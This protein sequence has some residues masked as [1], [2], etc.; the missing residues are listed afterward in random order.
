MKMERTY[1]EEIIEK[2]N[3]EKKILYKEAMNI[4]NKMSND[5]K[6]NLDYQISVENYGF[7]ADL[8]KIGT[9]HYDRIEN[10]SD[11]E[12]KEKEL[13]HSAISAF[14]KLGE[15]CNKINGYR[16]IIDSDWVNFDGDIVITD[17]C[18]L[19]NGFDY[20][21]LDSVKYIER[22][23]IYGD[24]SCHTY[25]S[26]T[27]KA[28]GKFCADSGMVAVISVDDLRKLDPTFY[29]D[30]KVKNSHMMTVIK[31]FHGKVRFRVDEESYTYKGEERKDYGVVVEGV[32]NINFF[33]SQTGL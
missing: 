12:K 1:V 25:D 5:N 19:K 9:W 28:L 23:T 3:K 14:R 29:N 24:W 21:Y 13:S 4:Y 18:Y 16:R 15:V 22:D 8:I 33:T 11:E 7:V 6:E 27:K 2:L 32:G 26:D 20:D 30:E 17:P 10:L 31:D